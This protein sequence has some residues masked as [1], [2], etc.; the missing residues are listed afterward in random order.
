MGRY[1][2][3]GHVGEALGNRRHMGDLAPSIRSPRPRPARVAPQTQR[4][5]QFTP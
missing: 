4:R 1:R 5:Q 3:G 2:A